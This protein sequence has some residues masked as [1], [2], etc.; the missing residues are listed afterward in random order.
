MQVIETL[1]Q[2]SIDVLLTELRAR[3]AQQNHRGASNIAAA[4]PLTLNEALREWDTKTIAKTLKEKQKVIY[5]VDDRQDLYQITDQANLTDADSV[6]A[7]FQDSDI[8]DKGDG[9][10][11]LRTRNFGIDRNLCS[12]EPFRS[13]PVGGFC[14]GFLVAEDVIATAGH[15]VNAGNVTNVRFVFGFRMLNANKAQTI[16]N[17]SEIYKGIS[18]VGRQQHSD[19]ADWA[20]VRIDRPVPDHNIASVRRDG[21][22]AKDQVVHIIGRPV[23]LPTKFA[24]GASVRDTKPSAYFVANL[25]SYGGNSGSPVF[26]SDTHEVEGVLVR[27]ETDF[28]MN[29]TCNVSMVCP[30]TGCRGE[31]VTRTTEFANLIPVLRSPRVPAK[32]QISAVSRSKDKLDIFVT[33]KNGV[34]LTAAWEPVFAHGWRGWWE[35]NGGRSASGAP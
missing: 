27:G 26:N 15:C 3:A 5:G 21:K 34:I 30:T 6:V 14:S 13:Q 22:I 2:F 10:S 32:A 25:D 12:G 28:V 18:I 16:I 20:L 9:T 4:A 35:I 33:D 31:D 8:A 23:G 1:E 11:S 24:G 17:N 19:G 29:G 7:L